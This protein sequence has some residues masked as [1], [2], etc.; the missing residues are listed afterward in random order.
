MIGYLVRKL[1]NFFQ[2]QLSI[3]EQ[4]KKITTKDSQMLKPIICPSILSGDFAILAD[5]CN[6]MLNHGA[7]W[8]HVDVMDG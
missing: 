4:A 1:T 7:D 2:R 5:E 6:R 3:F 8:L